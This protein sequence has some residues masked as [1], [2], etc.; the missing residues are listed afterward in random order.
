[1]WLLK[2]LKYITQLISQ[3][4]ETFITFISSIVPWLVPVVPAYITY[5]HSIDDLQFWL[6]VAICVG[7]SVEGLG[8]TSMY[9]TFQFLEHNRKYK[10]DKKKSPWWIPA[11]TYA[12]YLAIIL[13]VNV[14]L[15]WQKGVNTYHVA[16]IAL[17]SLLSL[18]AGVLIAVMAVHNE[19]VEEH[20]AVLAERKE[21]RKNKLVLVPAPEEKPAS[22]YREQIL[23]ILED[24]W[25]QYHQIAGLRE[26]AERLN[27]DRQK[28][29]SYIWSQRNEWAEKKGIDLK[30]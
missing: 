8:L 11:I 17:L 10:D 22:A 13:I 6:P 4:E 30:Q 3:G 14:V 12:A 23:G 1:M 24:D 16:A 25:E 29:K 27:L 15:D 20:R 5:R 21:S 28:S 26:I 19:R 18:P 2:G 9:R 7:I